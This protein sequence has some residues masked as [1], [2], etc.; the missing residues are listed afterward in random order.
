MARGTEIGAFRGTEIGGTEGF[1]EGYI[2]SKTD[3][4]GGTLLIL[5]LVP[6]RQGGYTLDF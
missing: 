3:H 1:G 5:R 6:D 2:L 4:Q